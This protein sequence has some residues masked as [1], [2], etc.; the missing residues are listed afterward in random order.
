M[1]GVVLSLEAFREKQAQAGF[2][3]QVHQAVDEMLDC[4]EVD[5]SDSGSPLP[6]LHE[7]TEAVRQDR[8]GLSATI[9]KAYVERVY[10]NYLRQ[11]RADCPQCGRSLKGRP[12]RRR[13]VETLV[14]SVTLERPYFHCPACQKGFY[15]L[16]EAL[17]LSAHTKQYDVQEAAT[18]LALEMPYERAMQ[19]LSKW[20]DATVSD[21][22]LHEFVQDFGTSL[23]L[24]DV[25]PTRDEVQARVAEVGTGQKWKPIMVLAIDGA[26]VP[27]RPEAAK[28]TRP[29]RKKVRARRSRWKGE[30]REAKGFRCYLVDEDR[31]VHLIS[32]HQVQTEEELGQALRQIQ[33]S[34]LI[35]EQTVRL[36]VVADG[37]PWIWKWV[38]QL[39]PSARQILDFYHCSTYLHAVAEA[40]YGADALRATQW[41]EAT[42]ARLFCN[43][44]AGVI[45]GLQR[46]KPVCSEAEQA[47]QRALTYFSPRLEQVTYGAHRKA[48]Y[49]IGSGAIESAH[50]FIVHARLKRSGAWWYQENSNAVLA[51]RCARYNGTMERV[52]LNHR[53]QQPT[54]TPNYD[55]KA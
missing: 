33:Q 52:F 44:G 42:M 32:W 26:D 19:V 54:S 22:V 36:C 6:R 49:P 11:D 14:G 16:D 46:M 5:M 34:G 7:L 28:G 35:P 2:R 1:S 43:E 29:G 15:P 18:E 9:V 41:L 48:G 31:I 8:A 10:G 30:Y 12:G 47:I 45:W 20:T 40:Q 3:T 37:A 51:L 50:R 25:C 17:G 53:R 23:G 55:P 4:L 39:F 38:E 13:T 27:T 24:L 21:C